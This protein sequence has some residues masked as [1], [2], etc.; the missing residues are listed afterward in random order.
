MS[1]SNLSVTHAVLVEEEIEFTLVELSRVCRADSALL[2]ALAAP[3]ALAD[4]L[5][6]L[7]TDSGKLYLRT[8]NTTGLVPGTELPDGAAV[9]DELSVFI[10]LDSEGRPIATTRI[11]KLELGE[12]T[13]VPEALAKRTHR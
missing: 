12:Q 6:K 2:L 9:G 13:T 8:E 10:Y 11:A 3:A 5:S 7:F 1:D 4:E